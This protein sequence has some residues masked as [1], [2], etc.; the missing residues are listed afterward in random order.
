MTDDRTTAQAAPA[1]RDPSRDGGIRGE[2]FLALHD[3]V[4]NSGQ[5]DRYLLVEYRCTNPAA[6]LLA[7]VYAT[8]RGMFVHQP[9]YVVSATVAAER[10][11]EWGKRLRPEAAYLMPDRT[12]TLPLACDHGRGPMGVTE[13][14]EDVSLARRTGRSTGRRVGSDGSR[15]ASAR[16]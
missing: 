14:L 8:P 5:L 6:C 11:I 15:R 1:F 16:L 9:A 4:R 7:R 3:T 13:V 2:Q 12:L 10:G